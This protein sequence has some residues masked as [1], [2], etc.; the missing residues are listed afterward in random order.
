[1]YQQIMFCLCFFEHLGLFDFEASQMLFVYL[2][3]HRLLVSMSPFRR[4][5]L[6]LVFLRASQFVHFFPTLLNDAIFLSDLSLRFRHPA[7]SLCHFPFEF[8]LSL[9]EFF[10][11]HLS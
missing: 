7:F 3:W 10:I 2:Q 1:M 8:L 5:N 6:Y 9:S 11:T 4:T